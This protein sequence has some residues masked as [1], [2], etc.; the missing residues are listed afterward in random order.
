MSRATRPFTA[1]CACAVHVHRSAN[2][3]QKYAR[4]RTQQPTRKQHL[5]YKLRCLLYT[6]KQRHHCSNGAPNAISFLEILSAVASKALHSVGVSRQPRAPAASSACLAFFAPA[7]CIKTCHD[8]CATRA[9]WK[10]N[11]VLPQSQ[12]MRATWQFSRQA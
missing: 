4:Q 6:Y 9:D 7:A 3:K 2:A 11:R 10:C 12:Q 8:A 1:G 5:L